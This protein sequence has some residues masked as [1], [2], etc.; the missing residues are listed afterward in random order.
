MNKFITQTQ[1]QQLVNIYNSMLSVHTCGEDSFAMT[2]AMRAL[3]Q[4]ILEVSKQ[5]QKETNVVE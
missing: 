5:D 1:L 4:T 3:Q 2:D